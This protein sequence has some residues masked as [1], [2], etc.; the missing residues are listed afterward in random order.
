MTLVSAPEQGGA[1]STRT[2]IP[3]RC[4][5]SIGVL[6]TMSVAS[7]CLVPGS[8]VDG[9]AQ[10]PEGDKKPLSIEHPS[11]ET[12]MVMKVSDTGNTTSAAILRTARKLMDGIVFA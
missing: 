7:A 5:A 3:H 1:I 8:V 11:G 10:V 9:L 12:T 6:G 2:I 4:H